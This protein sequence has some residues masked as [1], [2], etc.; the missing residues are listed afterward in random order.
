M[1]NKIVI[2]ILSLFLTG[3][4]RKPLLDNLSGA[5]VTQEIMIDK[6]G[7]WIPTNIF[8][9]KGQTF[10]ITAKGNI[11][12]SYWYNNQIAIID[13]RGRKVS[14]ER[15]IFIPYE[16]VGVLV[17]R[18]GIYSGVYVFGESCDGISMYDGVLEL[19]INNS[20]YYNFVSGSYTV[21]VTIE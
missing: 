4:E 18:I 17:G 16:N 20:S 1:K 21:T 10:R 6:W 15:D 7:Q 5:K 14:D 12:L 13:P 19:G 8:I 3:C 9:K 11:S 2:I